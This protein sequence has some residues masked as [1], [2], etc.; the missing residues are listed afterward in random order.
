MHQVIPL[1]P[2]EIEE[3]LRIQRDESSSSSFQGIVDHAHGSYSLD[4]DAAARQLEQ[5]QGEGQV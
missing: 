4:L 1:E 2:D 3:Q 5:E